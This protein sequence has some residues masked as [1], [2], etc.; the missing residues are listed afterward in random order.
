MRPLF[1]L[2]QSAGLLFP[3]AVSLLLNSIRTHYHS[4]KWK[5]YILRKVH[6]TFK[7]K[8]QTKRVN[9]THHPS[10]DLNLR[11]LTFPPISAMRFKHFVMQSTSFYQALRLKPSSLSET[12]LGILDPRIPSFYGLC[13]R[14]V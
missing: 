7:T 6:R 1:K 3:S 2:F 13:K 5:E 9:E 14:T 4:Y 8:K 10:S 11:F 12:F